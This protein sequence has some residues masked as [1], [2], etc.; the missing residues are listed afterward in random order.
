MRKDMPKLLCETP[1]LGSSEKNKDVMRLRRERIIEYDDGTFGGYEATSGASGRAGMR[2]G[3]SGRHLFRKELNENLSPLKRFLHSRVGQP[4]D[5]VYSEI[6]EANPNGSAVTEHIYEHLFSYVKLHPLIKGKGKARRVYDPVAYKRWRFE[7]YDDGKTFY[8]DEGGI[9]RRP[10]R[11]LPQYRR[12]TVEDRMDVVKLNERTYYMRREE[13]GL[14]FLVRLSCEVK[15]VTVKDDKT[16]TEYDQP[17]RVGLPDGITPLRGT[18]EAS[19][20]GRSGSPYRGKE[21]RTYL[22]VSSVKSA[23]KAEIEEHNLYGKRG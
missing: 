16:V 5:K 4:W 6:K 17:G 2:P 13:D 15:T 7:L 19:R 18:L 23:S 10:V 21:G 9:L 22:Y 8:V 14:W 1:R 3:K 12:R 20:F 11:K